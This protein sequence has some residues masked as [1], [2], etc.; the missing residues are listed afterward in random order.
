MGCRVLDVA[1]ASSDL[2]TDKRD[3]YAAW[4]PES[5][6]RTEAVLV[7]MTVTIVWVIWAPTPDAARSAPTLRIELFIFV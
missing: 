4:D 5:L 3:E 7:C 2:S 6:N 1:A